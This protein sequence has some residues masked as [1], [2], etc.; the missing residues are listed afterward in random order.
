MKK[1]YS[2]PTVCIEELSLSQQIASCGAGSRGDDNPFGHATATSRTSCGFKLDQFGTVVFVNGN[3]ACK[4]IVK[5]GVNVGGV[6]YNTVAAGYTIF[7]S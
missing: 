6:C 5:P 4:M 1:K 7:S 2:K 3:T